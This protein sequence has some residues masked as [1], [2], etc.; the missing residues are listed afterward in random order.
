DA[1][2]ITQP[3]SDGRGA[4]LAMTRALRQHRGSAVLA[5]EAWPSWLTS[6]KGF[7]VA[8]LQPS[9]PLYFPSMSL[10]LL[11]ELGYLAVELESSFI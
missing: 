5:M 9:L 8:R 2:H 7:R 3:P 11:Y 6:T 1:Y 10:S 4:I